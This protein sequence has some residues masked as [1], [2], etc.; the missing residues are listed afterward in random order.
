MSI[1]DVTKKN[2]WTR[3]SNCSPVCEGF[4]SSCHHGVVRPRRFPRGFLVSLRLGGI[5]FRFARSDQIASDALPLEGALFIFAGKISNS[6]Y[7]LVLNPSSLPSINQT[8]IPKTPYPPI[9][10]F[11]IE[12]ESPARSAFRNFNDVKTDPRKK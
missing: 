9:T 12:F 11:F 3:L 4:S 1:A 7:S 5:L 2:H 6:A 10:G 8:V